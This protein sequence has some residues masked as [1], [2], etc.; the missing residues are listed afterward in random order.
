MANYFPL[1]V[2]AT[3]HTIN[4]LPAGANLDLTSSDIV[5]AGNITS[6]ANI[7]AAYFIGDGG[8]L[9]NLAAIS[10]GTSNIQVALNG[11]ITFSS[12]GNANVLTVTDTTAIANSFTANNFIVGDATTTISTQA[13]LS[14]TTSSATAGQV[15]YQI[16]ASQYSAIDF[17]IIATD[18]AGLNRQSTKITTVTFGSNT[19]W[20]E[21]DR[22]AINTVVSSFTVDQNAGNVRLLANPSSANLIQYTSV[23]TLYT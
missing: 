6:V 23:I 21:F 4:E 10:N 20:N 14:T 3:A 18:A 13:W 17:R 7:S 5:N 12:N 8:L 9:S 15:L 16:P 2:D 11:N 19:S 1:I 22:I